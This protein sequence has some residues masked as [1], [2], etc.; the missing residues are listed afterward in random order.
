MKIEKKGI[1]VQT[2]RERIWEQ[3][4]GDKKDEKVDQS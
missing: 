3:I 1:Q 4:Y 2:E